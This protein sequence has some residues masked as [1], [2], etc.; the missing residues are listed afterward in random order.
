MNS[1]TIMQCLVKTHVCRS[2]QMPCMCIAQCAHYKT[3]G[4][5]TFSGQFPGQCMQFGK[6]AG[7]FGG[8]SGM[9]RRADCRNWLHF[10]RIP[11]RLSIIG[12]KRV[13]KT[14]SGAKQHA[15]TVAI[16]PCPL[17]T[18]YVSRFL[19]HVL[20]HTYKPVFICDAQMRCYGLSGN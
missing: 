3:E 20:P 1:K 15:Y 13:Y 6:S 7:N 4:N 8:R 18:G 17:F 11:C 12:R 19:Y 10:Y 14:V 9:I 2:L 16:I 5:Y